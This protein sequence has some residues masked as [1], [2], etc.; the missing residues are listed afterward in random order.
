MAI[1]QRQKHWTTQPPSGVQINFSHPL[2]RGLTF[3]TLYNAGAGLQQVLLPT[4]LPEHTVGTVPSQSWIAA[5]GGLS[6]N[7]NGNWSSWYER[8]PWVEPSIQVTMV[9][10]ARRTGTLGS[11]SRTAEKTYNNNSNPFLSYGLDY[12]PSNA[13]QDT[14]NAAVTTGGTVHGGTNVVLAAGATLQEHT[15]GMTYD[16]AHLAA[17]FNGIRKQ[18]DAVTGTISYDTSSTGRFIVAGVSSA[19]A[20]GE[21]IGQVYYA[22]VWNR[23]LSQNE[24][25]WLHQDPY[26]I[27][28]SK[29]NNLGANQYTGREFNYFITLEKLWPLA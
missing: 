10:R 3:Y 20:L 7:W 8:G 28:K 19:S 24:M 15:S 12:N 17:Y 29:L 6:H 22:A 11:D 9:T 4:G 27:L 16:G 2:A 25:M 18:N 5:P 23:A 21:W 1:H 26:G 13:G 14:F